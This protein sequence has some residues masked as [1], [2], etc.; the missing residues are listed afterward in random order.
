MNP[1]KPDESASLL[2]YLNT[3]CIITER[4]KNAHY[5]SALHHERVQR[6]LGVSSIIL[7]V[8]VAGSLFTN[9][10]VY[11]GYGTKLLQAVT[12]LAAAALSSLQIFLRSSEKAQT[13]KIFASKYSDMERRMKLLDASHSADNKKFKGQIDQFSDELSNIGQFA[14]FVEVESI[15]VLCTPENVAQQIEAERR[16]T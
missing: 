3:L 14:P 4:N 9:L 11:L 2:N 1:K 7:G 12:S 6:F 5:A 16:R 10:E 13:H 8:L 15:A